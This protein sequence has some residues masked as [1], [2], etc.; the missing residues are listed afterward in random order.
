MSDFKLPSEWAPQDAIMLTWP[1][2]DTDW[3]YM[4]DQVEQVYRELAKAIASLLDNPQRMQ[5]YGQ[6]GREIA[7]NEFSLQ[8]VLD[9]TLA[10]YKKL[11]GKKWPG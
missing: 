9:E 4:L 3:A 6:A 10:L 7:V 8:R 5:Q 1:H 11:L 2:Q